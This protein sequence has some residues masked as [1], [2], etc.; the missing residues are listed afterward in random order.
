[1][2][3][4]Q[5]FFHNSVPAK[6]PNE[7]FYEIHRQNK[8][9]R[10][11]L[12]IYIIV[13]L[14]LAVGMQLYGQLRFPN[15]QAIMDNLSFTITPDM[16]VQADDSNPDYPYLIR[17]Y[18]V[19]KNGNEEIVPAVSVEYVFYDANGET[20]GSYTVSGENVGALENWAFDEGIYADVAPAS[21]E[22]SFWFDETSGFYTLLNFTQTFVIFLGLLFINKIDFKKDWKAFKRNL[23][24]Y[25]PS[26]FGGYILVLVVLFAA[27]YL[28]NVLGVTGTSQN[29]M[30]IR[31]MFS[32]NTLMNVILVITLV[33]LTPVVE[34]LVFR[35]AIFHFSSRLI[36]DIGAVIATGAVFGLMHVISYGD[37]I[38]S[39][40]YIG[41]GLVFGFIYYKAKK[42]IYVSIGVHFLNNLVSVLSYLA[43]AQIF[44]VL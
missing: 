26:I 28:L 35:K 37:F 29:E 27:Q 16:V 11:I 18:G 12:L 31:S 7:E 3:E 43:V 15:P 10:N 20:I 24:T 14:I 21:F 34:E 13:Q 1:M 25:I 23:G 36:G 9:N 2:Y 30:A 5:D 8:T 6:D 32:S 17:I 38:Q 40:P 42:V 4:Q 39:I 19:M 22:I 33:V 44:P 41:M